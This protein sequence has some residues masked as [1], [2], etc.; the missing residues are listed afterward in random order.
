[1]SRVV[2]LICGKEFKWIT[3]LHLK[4]HGITYAE[5][6]EKFPDAETGI[7]TWNTGKTKETDIRVEKYAE[8]LSNTMKEFFMT[9]EGIKER[10]KLRED[11]LGMKASEGTKKKM[12][13]SRF[14]FNKTDEGMK[15]MQQQSKNMKGENN[16]MKDPKIREIHS[17]AMSSTEF[18]QNRSE[19]MLTDKNPMKDPIVAKKTGDSQRGEKNHMYGL[20]GEETPN[21]QG[22]ISFEPYCIKFNKEFKDRVRD[23]FNGCCYVCGVGQSEL[24]QKLDVHHVNYNKMVCCND[25]KPLFV[26]LCRS[27]HA[28]TLRDREYW[29][30]FFTISLEYLTDGQ[31]FLP[32]KEHKK[33]NTS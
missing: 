30:E 3:G 19:Y 18:R 31:C 23:F 14:E 9:E 8:T 12:K 11:H 22:G 16:P 28:K 7:K 26:P 5:Y 32:K 15:F 10:K 2:C 6:L 21:W 4:T 13:D 27:C 25:V 1:M 29:E 20:R 24:G 33:C 17:D